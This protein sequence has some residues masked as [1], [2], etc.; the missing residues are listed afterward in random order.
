MPRNFIQPMREEPDSV[1]NQLADTAKESRL[2]IVDF[3]DMSAKASLGQH[4]TPESIVFN[5]YG[6]LRAT[7]T[8]DF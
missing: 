7:T 1:P 2:Q 8:L 4:F 3:A 6:I 5:F